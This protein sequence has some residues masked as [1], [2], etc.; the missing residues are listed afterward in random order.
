MGNPGSFELAPHNVTINNLLPE[1]FDT[2]R[3]LQMAHVAM[4]T[5]HIDF[6]EARRRQVAV[7]AA[8]RMGRPKKFGATCAFVCSAFSGY[9]SGKK[10]PSQ[11]WNLSGPHLAL[12]RHGG[13]S[14]SY[15]PSSCIRFP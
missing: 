9:L 10:H 12:P 8:K 11:R 5:Q 15:R 6:D 7:I 1:R 3:Q 14:A 4:E 13:R 2:D